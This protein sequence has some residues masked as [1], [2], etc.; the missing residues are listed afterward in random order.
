MEIEI[1][2]CKTESSTTSEIFFQNENFQYSQDYSFIKKENFVDLN[3]KEDDS[4]LEIIVSR[5]DKLPFCCSKLEIF[6]T[7]NHIELYVNDYEYIETLNSSNH[8]F[9][10]K[11]ELSESFSGK[12]AILRLFGE[13][14]ITLFRIQ[15]VQKIKE[16]KKFDLASIFGG[17]PMP[18]SLGNKEMINTLLSSLQSNPMFKNSPKFNFSTPKKTVIQK[19]EKE[20]EN[21][22][23]LLESKLG[24]LDGDALFDRLK[25]SEKFKNYL[26]KLIDER[27]EILLSQ[28]DI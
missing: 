26:N 17:K 4:K 20:K 7:T 22:N 2:N 13:N 11:F 21:T 6:S 3:S 19:D 28:R 15:M 18:T 12:K 27:L 5:K 16:E 10:N 23:D 25:N 14:K 9:F 1:C 8:G 24:T